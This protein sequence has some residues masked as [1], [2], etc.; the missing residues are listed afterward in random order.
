MTD[1]FLKTKRHLEGFRAFLIKDY[2]IF[3]SYKLVFVGSL[4]SIIIGMIIFFNLSNFVEI[5]ENQYLKKYGN[6]YFVFVILGLAI[7]DLCNQIASALSREMRN[8]LVTGIFEE[9]VLY[10]NSLASLF[11][12][13]Y[14]FP[15]VQG[16]IRF[17]LYLMIAALVYGESAFLNVFSLEVLLILF[18]T[19]LSFIGFG[20][21]GSAFVIIFK[22]GDPINLLNLGATSILSGILYPT[23]VLPA[24]LQN[25]SQF[26]PITH[27]LELIRLSIISDS[28]LFEANLF[29]WIA[30]LGMSLFL[31]FIGLLLARKSVTIAKRG[32]L[33]IY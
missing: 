6:N 14:A 9:L 29:N 15:I 23:S 13:S 2:L 12:Y 19:I 26:L 28:N 27:S 17:Y 31:I 18:L 30:L 5:N 16:L 24:F 20:L 22:R 4:I 7:V 10:S 25:L 8:N 3:S 1:Y 11:I 33:L 32:G 21:I